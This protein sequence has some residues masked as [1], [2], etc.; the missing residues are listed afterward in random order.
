ME[1]CDIGVFGLGVMGQNLA[2]NLA[3]HGYRVAGYD[4]W[5]EPRQ[6]FA[7]DGQGGERLRGCE[8]VRAFVAMLKRPR[9]ILLLIQA[10]E[11][12]DRALAEIA[13]LLEPGDTLIDGG[14]EHYRQ[15]ERRHSELVQRSLRWLGMGVSGGEEGARHGPSLMPG[16]DRSSY[17]DLA[18]LLAKIA[19]QA[20]GPCV[21]YVGPGGSGHYVKM[22][23]NGIEYADMQLIAESYD[24]L[25]NLTALSHAEL[26]T[27]FARWNEGELES[28]L[29]AITATI[30]QKR[31]DESGAPLLELVSDVAQ[32]KGTGAWTVEEAARLGVPVPTIAA[33]VD[34][35]LLSALQRERAEARA[36]RGPL[37]QL[38]CDESLVQDIQ[39]ALYAAKCC[40]YAQGMALLSAGSSAHGYALRLAEIARIWTGGCIIRARLLQ[41][42]KR[43]YGRAPELS[44]LLLDGEVQVEL[45]QRQEALRR[46][47]ARA[48]LAGV[49]VP[50][51]AS[52]LAYYDTLRRPR[53]PQR[54][55]Q[56]QRDLFGAHGY[57][58]I[59]RPGKHHSDWTR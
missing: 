56:A 8:D 53:L 10:G 36:L 2:L 35:R 34:G 32:M 24:L 29:I 16:G 38:A 9:R 37:A 17:D 41:S 20:D 39:D 5:P 11:A 1:A 6:R 23:H 54:L 31:D 52:A 3:D 27:L 57:E 47:V 45:A 30:L 40:A 25:S 4:S 15:T 46:V 13:P 51:H 14:N 19:A 33:A 21:T 43:A 44:N 26:A 22:V 42:I 58:R 48:A 18:P 59:D 7:A 50:A 28:Y 55:I 12:V 49:P